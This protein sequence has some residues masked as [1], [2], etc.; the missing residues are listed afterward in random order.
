MPGTQIVLVPAGTQSAPIFLTPQTNL[1]AGPQ[2]LGGSVIVE[3]APSINGPWLAWNAGT[4]LA[5][6]SFRPSTNMYARVTA[7]TQAGIAIV[8]DIGGANQP[9]LD[10]LVSANFSLA[11]PSSTSIQKLFSVRIPPLYLPPNFRCELRGSVNLTNNA[12]VKTLTCTLNG[13]GGTSFFTSPSLASNAN[14]NFMAAFVGQGASSL[15]GVGAGATGGLGLSTTAF[16]TLAYDYINGELEV[17]VC[18]TKATGTD[19][20]SLESLLMTIY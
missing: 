10:Q 1:C 16:T 15:K 6:D 5:A 13:T 14:Y 7:A 11:S 4:S 18:A 8:A 20:F 9:T 19:T 3:T 12:N 17:C 2:V